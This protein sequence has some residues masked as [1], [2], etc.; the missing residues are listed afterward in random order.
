MKKIRMSKKEFFQMLFSM[1]LVLFL[2]GFPLRIYSSLGDSSNVFSTHKTP[3]IADGKYWAYHGKL[4]WTDEP[5]E[6]W[7]YFTLK[8]KTKVKGQMEF[9]GIFFQYFDEKGDP[10]YVDF[11]ATKDQLSSRRHFLIGEKRWFDIEEEFSYTKYAILQVTWFDGE[12]NR[13][14]IVS[15]DIFTEEDIAQFEELCKTVDFTFEDDKS[16]AE[17]FTPEEHRALDAFEET[18]LHRIERSHGSFFLGKD[19]SK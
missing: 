14:E 15:S 10:E 1:L 8:E 12:K 13:Q 16:F 17:Q 18:F 4:N 11:Y 7:T 2:L 9:Q 3:V 19:I 6:F 5:E